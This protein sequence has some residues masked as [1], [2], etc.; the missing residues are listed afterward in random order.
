M[1][2]R[3]S[4][5]ALGRRP[6]TDGSDPV[7]AFWR[8]TSRNRPA[9]SG[10]RRSSQAPGSVPERLQRSRRSVCSAPSAG[11]A[12]HPGGSVPARA[13]APAAL[14]AR[15]ADSPAGPGSDRLTLAAHEHCGPLDAACAA[16]V[17][18]GAAAQPSNTCDWMCSDRLQACP[19]STHSCTP[20][21]T[22]ASGPL[23]AQSGLLDDPRQASS[24]GARQGQG[25]TRQARVVAQDE[26]AQAG[27][28][29]RW[30]H[31]GRVPVRQRAAQP[32]PARVKLLQ[33][34]Q[35]GRAGAAAGHPQRA[36]HGA[37][38]P[39]TSASADALVRASITAGLCSSG[40][41]AGS[42]GPS[43]KRLAAPSVT[44]SVTLI[45]SARDGAVFRLRVLSWVPS[46]RQPRAS[47]RCFST[48][49]RWQRAAGRTLG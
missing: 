16:H 49:A 48:R 47:R 44:A 37:P 23:D 26:L 15:P 7:S 22:R 10:S 38:A 11:A 35:R 17:S 29:P 27:V 33:V 24:A 32:A 31:A 3:T 41:P 2:C 39:A 20:L 8:S 6:H 12:A 14:S 13:R 5:E 25:R 1:D 34:R 36:R 46:A 21:Q 40:A 4:T 45:T 18:K 28:L 30:E 9:P 42:G 43:I 19:C